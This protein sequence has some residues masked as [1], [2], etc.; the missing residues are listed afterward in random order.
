MAALTLYPRFD[1]G[2]LA[3]AN[4][5]AE[6]TTKTGWTVGTN[7]PTKYKLMEFN[8][9]RSSSGYTSTALPNENPVGS[10][11]LVADEA[12]TGKFAA[13]NWALL[14]KAIAVT[15][16]GDQDGAARVRLW[17]T[18]DKSAF[19]ALTAALDLSAVTDLAVGAAQSMNANLEPGAIELKAEYLALQI[20][21]KVT[22]AGGA[23]DRDV[24]FREGE[25]ITLVTAN[26]EPAG[27]GPR[28]GSLS[29]LG[30]GR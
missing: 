7:T 3:V 8:A 15:S 20:A 29:L 4:P 24:L 30:V 27:S 5:G 11:V 18:A 21:W 23:A 22:G 25:G 14:L 17:K 6:K 10:D 26:F 12:L 1:L 16:G 9:E 2:T 19:T 28:P 13:E